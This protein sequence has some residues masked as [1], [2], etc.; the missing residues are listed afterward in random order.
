MSNALVRGGTLVTVRGSPA[1]DVLIEGERIAAVGSGLSSADAEVIDATRKLVLPGGIDPHTHFDLPMFD[2]V[3][4]DDH[5]SGLK[6]AACGGTTT[7][8]DFVPQDF[9]SLHQC[10]QAWHAKAAATAPIDFSFP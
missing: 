3:S 5:Y 6:A 2:T 8:L 9:A 10:V 4:S 1:A 7:V